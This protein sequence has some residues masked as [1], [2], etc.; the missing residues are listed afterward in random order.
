MNKEE[1]LKE[2]TVEG[3]VIKLPAGQLDRKV[4]M[5]VKKALEGIG[6]KWKGGKVAGFVFASD[7]TDLLA[8]VAGGKKINLKKDFQFFGTPAGLADKVIEYAELE[9][10]YRILE[11][12][13]GTGAL[14]EAVIRDI[15][16]A[17]KIDCIELMPQ[18]RLVLEKL[19]YV[20]LIGEDFMKMDLDG[21]YDAIIANPPFT[22]GQDIAH[23]RKMYDCLDKRGV[24][25]CI[26]GTGW[27]RSENKKPKAFKEWLD[28]MEGMADWKRFENIGTDAQFIRKNGDRVY[29]EMVE[30]G[31]FK[32]SGTNVRTM[33]VV[34]EKQN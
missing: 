12:E 15:G 2:C 28:D 11:P 3:T 6:G 25:S 20:N 23:F 33:I 10:G 30:A 5:E 1:T 21:K 4:Y 14:A 26:L 13:A 34:I 27:L 19:S 9:E 32:E 29:L 22:K 31:T 24:V 18:N 17:T 7:P 16:T 8:E